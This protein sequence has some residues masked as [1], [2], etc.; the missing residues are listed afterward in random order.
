MTTKQNMIQDHYKRNYP[1]DEYVGLTRNQLEDKLA[2]DKMVE[3][4]IK[5]FYSKADRLPILSTTAIKELIKSVI[6]L[7]CGELSDRLESLDHYY[8]LKHPDDTNTEVEMVKASDIKE[9]IKDLKR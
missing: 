4:L 2:K 9:L 6:F 3:N 1:K 7:T 8:R 5:N